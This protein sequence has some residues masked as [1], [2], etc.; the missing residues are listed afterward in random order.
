MS[1]PKI[2]K[3]SEFDAIFHLLKTPL[4][5]IILQEERL[6]LSFGT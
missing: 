3:T 2:K 6:E 1:T 5:E 4:S